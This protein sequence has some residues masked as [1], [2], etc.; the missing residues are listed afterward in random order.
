M[1][2]LRYIEDRAIARHANRKS[3]DCR[4]RHRGDRNIVG[5]NIAGRRSLIFVKYC[6]FISA[7]CDLAIGVIADRQILRFFL[8]N[9]TYCDA[10]LGLSWGGLAH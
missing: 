9:I 1:I 7:M 2:C 6:H 10:T 8:M 3:P 5:R 4:L